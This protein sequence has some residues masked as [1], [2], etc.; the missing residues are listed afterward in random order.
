M[1]SM[2]VDAIEPAVRSIDETIE[3]LA[4]LG[5]GGEE[6]ALPMRHARL[7]CSIAARRRHVADHD[8]RAARLRR[9]VM[10][11]LA[12]VRARRLHAHGRR[13]RGH[14][15]QARRTFSMRQAAPLSTLSMRVAETERESS[16]PPGDAPA[17]VFIWTLGGWLAGT[18]LVG[19]AERLLGDRL[20]HRLRVA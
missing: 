2:A 15:G 16:C 10:R 11:Q 9:E 13:L 8:G 14:G 17:S 6:N 3:L 12:R 4:M 5:D 1:K 18:H 7:V 20:A 19:E